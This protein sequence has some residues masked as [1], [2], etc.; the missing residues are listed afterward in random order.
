MFQLGS[1]FRCWRRIGGC[2]GGSLESN[3]AVSGSE[4]EAVGGGTGG[5]MEGSG[6]H[7]CG[8]A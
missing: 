2:S 3:G 7:Q 5:R 6:A 8:Q 4:M 1:G